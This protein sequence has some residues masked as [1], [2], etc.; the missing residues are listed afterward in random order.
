MK[1]IF[2]LGGKIIPKFPKQLPSVDRFSIIQHRIWGQLYAK[3]LQL[4]GQKPA[5]SEK[6][7][8][9]AGSFTNL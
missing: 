9:K 8:A 6:A 3:C 1:R 2:Q 4:H 7:A 5:S